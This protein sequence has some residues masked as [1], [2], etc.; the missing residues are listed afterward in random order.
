LDS[1]QTSAEEVPGL[2]THDELQRWMVEHDIIEKE[3]E[4]FDTGEMTKLRQ[5]TK[6]KSHITRLP[7]LL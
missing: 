4:I 2:P 3:T 7:L 5:L 6:G 1:I